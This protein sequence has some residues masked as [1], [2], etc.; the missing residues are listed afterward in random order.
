MLVGVLLLSACGESPTAPALA[1]VSLGRIIF[2]TSEATSQRLSRWFGL[3][4]III[5]NV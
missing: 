1:D 3:A 5:D 4:P 2:V